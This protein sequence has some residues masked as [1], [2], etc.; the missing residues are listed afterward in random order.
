MSARCGILIKIVPVIFEAIRT[1]KSELN[2]NIQLLPVDTNE[3]CTQLSVSAGV[4]CFDILLKT[5][6]NRRA[7]PSKQ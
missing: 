4:N 3:H 6:L 1:I 7:Q 2:Q 5:G